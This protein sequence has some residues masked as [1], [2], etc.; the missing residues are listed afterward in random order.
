MVS[1]KWIKGGG[2]VGEERQNCKIG[3]S[4]ASKNKQRTPLNSDYN[5]WYKANHV[6]DDFRHFLTANYEP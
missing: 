5:I 6:F 1:L 3:N 2:S 4:M